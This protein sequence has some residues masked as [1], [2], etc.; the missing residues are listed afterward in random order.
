MKDESGLR[1]KDA[2]INSKV[3]YGLHNLTVR[4]VPRNSAHCP[5]KCFFY[6]CSIQQCRKI[7]CMPA[8]RTDGENVYFE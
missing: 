1:Y 2:R 8:E 3:E 4:K 7:A 5:S 6:D